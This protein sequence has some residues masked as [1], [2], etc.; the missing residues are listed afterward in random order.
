MR[1]ID[2]SHKIE[3]NM[4]IYPG[5]SRISLCQEKFLQKDTVFGL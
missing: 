3:H 1:L 2:L 5:D 4:P